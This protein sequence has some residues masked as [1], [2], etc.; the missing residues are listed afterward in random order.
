MMMMMTTIALGGKNRE[1]ERERERGKVIH[2]TFLF[3]FE[4]GE[5]IKSVILIRPGREIV[6]TATASTEPSIVQCCLVI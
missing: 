1:R 3:F 5:N 2:D 4:Q 6:Y